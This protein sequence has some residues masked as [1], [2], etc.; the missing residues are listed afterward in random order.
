MRSIA[1]KRITTHLVVLLAVCVSVHAQEPAAHS[2]SQLDAYMEPGM[3]VSGV[4]APYY[5]DEGNLQA[6]LFGGHV[7]VLEGG[8]AKVENLRVDVYEDGAVIM[9]LFAPQCSMQVEDVDGQKQ[10]SINS[11]GD[12]LIEMDELA[13][14]GKGFRF[15]SD[16]NRFE[17][18]DQSRVLVKKSARKIEGLTL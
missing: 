15:S 16:Q 8:I 13:I 2:A 9:T 17:I 1:M 3:E 6:E 10:L 4:R 7:R 12:V 18:L 14:S 5:D 11:D